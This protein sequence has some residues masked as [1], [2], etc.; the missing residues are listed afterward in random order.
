MLV[1]QGETAWLARYA[2]AVA[3]GCLGASLVLTPLL[4]LDGLVL[5]TAIPYAV[6]FPFFLRFALGKL[7][8]SLG[9]LAQRAWLPAYPLAALLAL[10]LLGARAAFDLD[11]LGE[12]LAVGLG[13]LAAY[14]VLFA[15]VF[16]DASERR[17]A[18]DVVRGVLR[19]G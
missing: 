16:L 19:A 11:T 12:V 17:L 4:G 5:G 9:D 15:A 13:G 1:A 8:A 18:V 2:W 6:S 3:L 14:W 7:P 10:A